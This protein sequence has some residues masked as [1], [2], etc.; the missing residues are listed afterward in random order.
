[1]SALKYFWSRVA[2]EFLKGIQI[3]MLCVIFA[4]KYVQ[5]SEQINLWGHKRDWL[6]VC[7]VCHNI[8]L[9]VSSLLVHIKAWPF[10]CDV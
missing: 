6:F 7:N 9:E 2:C 4:L 5:C 10:D 3:D 1:M 8:F